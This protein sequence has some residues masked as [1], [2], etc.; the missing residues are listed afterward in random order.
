MKEEGSFWVESEVPLP[1]RQNPSA[2]G[3]DMVMCNC[4]EDALSCW[5]SL[6]LA[7]KRSGDRILL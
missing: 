7:S 1:P 5:L 3:M 2:T 4:Q 6:V